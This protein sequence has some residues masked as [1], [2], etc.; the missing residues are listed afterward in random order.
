M[1]E[2]SKSQTTKGCLIALGFIV[3]LVAS[4]SHVITS[5]E[6]TPDRAKFV[7]DRNLKIIIPHPKPGTPYFFPVPG[8]FD[9]IEESLSSQWDGVTTWAEVKKKEGPFAEFGLPNA[10]GWKGFVFYGKP[11]PLWQDFIFKPQSRWDDEGFWRY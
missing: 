11:I 8:K 5:S 7:F 2:E 9:N 1:T 4:F 6:A 3:I 10:Q